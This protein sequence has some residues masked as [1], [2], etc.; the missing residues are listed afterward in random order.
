MASDN[1]VGTWMAAPQ[2]TE[3]GNLPPAPGLAD[4]T[5]RQVVRA[6]LGGKRIRVKFCNEFGTVPLT[7]TAAHVARP[8]G[9]D[10]SPGLVGVTSPAIRSETGRALTFHGRPSVTIP[11][12]QAAVSDPLAFDLPALSDLVVTLH[13]AT[14][15]REITGHPGSRCTSYLAAGKHVAAPD[16]PGAVRVDHWYFLSGV[17]V[18]APAG[19]HAVVTLGDSITDGRGSPTN[20]NGR[21]PDYLAARLRA[22]SVGVLNAGIGGNCV[23][24]GG[25]GPTA[26]ARLDRD[27]LAQPGARWLVLFEGINDLGT[28]GATAEE[29]IAAFGQIA[30]RAKARGLKVY[31]ATIL[32]CG[33]S[34]YFTPELEAARQEV[35]RWIRTTRA[36]DAVLDFDA[37]LRDPKDPTRLSAAARSTD[38]LHPEGTAY[39]LLAESIDLRLFS[40]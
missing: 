9:G 2:L 7:L 14:P 31:G 6:T 16:L 26:L 33:G 23:V 1:W 29:L 37:V 30:R 27:V 19:A 28:R 5:L 4:T 13:V 12:G 18:A 40:G 36:L 34:F 17:E 8:V 22:E 3:P 20:G 25:L 35:N 11:P 21:W 39:R 32:P 10:A 38:H 15:S 24:R